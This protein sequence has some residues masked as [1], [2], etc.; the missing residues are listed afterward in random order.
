MFFREDHH[1]ERVDRPKRNHGN[2]FRV[3][4]NDPFAIVRETAADAL[5]SREPHLVGEPLLVA[6]RTD[7]EP[8]VRLA[9]ARSL[10]QVGGA[11]LHT[12]REDSRLEQGVR[13]ILQAR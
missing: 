3:L 10:R 5:S 1:F 6:A 7:V 2:E 12:A 9:A 13:E 11:L 4:A 8:R